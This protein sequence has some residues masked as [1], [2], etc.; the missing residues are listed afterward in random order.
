MSHPDV[1]YVPY[2]DTLDL[3]TVDD[4]M[5]VCEDVYRMHA[6][7]TVQ[8]S[9]APSFKL[10]VPA[11]YHNHWHVKGVMLSDVPITGVRLYNYFDDGNYNNVGYLDCARY[12]V[13]SDPKTGQAL[14]IVDEHW[15]YAVRS[16]AAAVV[17]CKWMGPA[18]PR[19]LG[20]IGIGTMGVNALRCLLTLYKFEEIR[21]T[22][23]RPETRKAF[24]EKWSRELGI[25]VTPVETPEQ[26]ARGADLVV[27]GTT[28]SDII[29]EEDWLKP[30]STFISLARRELNPAGWSKMDKVVID[31][32]ELNYMQPFFREMADSGQFTEE[33]LHGHIHDV[34]TG[35]RPGRE[36]AGERILIHT[37]GL[38]SQ[39]VAICHD[40]FR[41]AQAK[42]LGITLPAAR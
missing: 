10:D 14:S 27:G 22:S 18:E 1:L 23:R 4:A 26:V 3:L 20:L 40:I 30:G 5:R 17:V 16:T 6:R 9:K 31:N 12:I 28:S 7:G 33:M 36:S 8:W 13:L 19:V 11:P 37:T 39:D 2:K 25:P 35:D 41:R 24:A 32:W 29:C 42:G 38:V 21:V 15:A 34:I